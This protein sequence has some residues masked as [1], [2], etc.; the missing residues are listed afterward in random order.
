MGAQGVKPAPAGT[1]PPPLRPFSERPE[2]AMSK[3]KDRL[4][5]KGNATASQ[6]NAPAPEKKETPAPEAAR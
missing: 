1:I 4:R 5:N 3:V 2:S 6:P